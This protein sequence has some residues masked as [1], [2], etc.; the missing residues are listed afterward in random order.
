MGCRY[1]RRYEFRI[2][3]DDGAQTRLTVVRPQYPS[4]S[5]WTKSQTINLG[6]LARYF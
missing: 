5:T 6:N 3:R 2:G 4:T 1:N